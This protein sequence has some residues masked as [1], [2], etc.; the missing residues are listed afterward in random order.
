MGLIL[1]ISPG[2]GLGTIKKIVQ[3][4]IDKVNAMQ[5]GIG[6][7]DYADVVAYLNPLEA[8]E[9]VVGQ[10]I[11]VLTIDTPDLW[12]SEV[13]ANSVPYTY[14][15]DDTLLSDINTGGGKLQIGYYSV[16]I[17]E[18]VGA[19][20]FE[21]LSNK[22]SNV[23]TDKTSTTKYANVKAIYDWAVGKFIDITKIVTTW[24]ATT[25]NTNV[26]S[27]KLVKDSLNLKAD[28]APANGSTS[29]LRALFT[30]VPQANCVYNTNTGYYEMNGITNLTELAVTK[31]YNFLQAYKNQS[32]GAYQGSDIR[33]NFYLGLNGNAFYNCMA[34]CQGETT[35]EVFKFY[36]YN[37]ITS[38]SLMFYN[39]L[40]LRTAETFRMTN[41]TNVVYVLNM[42]L[43][44]VLLETAYLYQLKVSLSF[45]WSP[46][47]SL[48]S[49]Q[50]LVTNRANGTT[51]ITITVHPTVWGYLNDAVNYPTWNALLVD[52]VNNQYIY[53]ASA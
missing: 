43:E 26:P 38:T 17:A 31:S 3:Q 30:S 27:E 2:A 22:S 13:K 25:L 8:T 47:L 23:D 35:L 29:A 51:R 28:I 36:I 14:V 19:G 40:N 10:D 44:C 6:K 39:C 16:S 18:S 45:A 52:A 15:D 50:Y 21:L 42:F 12:I 49:L 48:A 1:G 33:T 53:F 5:L 24:T 46:L 7:D 41:I 9:L 4:L 34:C 32:S 11:Y 20:V 37:S